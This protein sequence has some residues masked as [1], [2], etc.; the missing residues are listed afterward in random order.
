MPTLIRAHDNRNRPIV[1]GCTGGA[2]TPRIHFNLLRLA[3]GQRHDFRLASFET[4][5][6]ALSGHCDIDVNDMRFAAVGGR[7]SVW[8]GKADS[9]YAPPGSAVCLVGGIDGAEVA[10]A[11]GACDAAAGPRPVPFRIGPDDVDVVEVGS[12]ETHSRRRIFHILGANGNGRTAGTLL[13][14]EL[15]ADAGCWSGY[16]PHKHDTDQEGET[17]HEELYHFRFDPESGFAG[18]FAYLDGQPPEAHLLR[19]G[20]TFAFARGYHP[21]VTSPGHREYIFTIL[22]GATQRALVQNFEP[23]HRHL[24]GAI[25]G[26]ARMREKFLAGETR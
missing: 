15:Y 5:S 2:P 19:H 22:V 6:V 14:S 18:Q 11:G 17:A 23:R 24:M 20:D 16:P 3:P 4:V 7:R 9:V 25:P 26:I 12:A 8:D 10:V 21:T 13:V 1:D